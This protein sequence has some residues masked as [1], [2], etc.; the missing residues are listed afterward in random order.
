MTAFFDLAAIRSRHSLPAIVGAS[1]KLIRAGREWKAS[2][3]LH[4]DRSPSFTIYEDGERYHCFGCG[5][6]GDVLDYLQR[7]HDVGLREAVAMLEG[8]NLPVVVQPALPPEPER[9]TTAEAITIWRAAGPIGGTPAEA[10]L[11]GRGL[12]LRLP[13]SLRFAR[14]RYGSKT[15]PCLVA[16]IANADNKIGG[17][18]RTFVKKDGS[19]KADV[20]A[21]KLSLGRIAGGAIR[22]APAAANLI[23]TGGLEDGLTLQQEMGLAVWAATGEGNMAGMALPVGVKVVTIGADRDEAGERHARRAADAFVEQ[24]RTVSIIRPLPGFND[25]NSELQGDRA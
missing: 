9:D 21:P 13:E 3:P 23:V 1:T 4:P 10:Y 5:A 20:P 12:D 16:L 25:F 11:R 15:L 6:G 24:G 7:A 17:V 2:C 14:L 19:A 18:Q 8:G 22:L